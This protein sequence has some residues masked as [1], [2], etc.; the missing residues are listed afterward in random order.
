M[1]MHYKQGILI[2]EQQVTDTSPL[3]HLATIP[4]DLQ[5]TSTGSSSQTVVPYTHTHTPLVQKLRCQT[6]IKHTT[7]IS[8]PP[9]IS[10]K[11]NFILRDDGSHTIRN[12]SE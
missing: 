7:N 6:P 11:Y 10:V 9:R 12:M 3:F 8:E 1:H 2:P 4:R 5:A